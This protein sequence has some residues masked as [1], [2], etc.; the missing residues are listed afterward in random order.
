MGPGSVPLALAAAIGLFTV[1]AVARP[2]R[3]EG[4]SAAFCARRAGRLSYHAK[5]RLPA[6]SFGLPGRRFPMPDVAHARNAKA[7]AVQAFKRGSITGSE[8]RRVNRK[9]D[10]II[11]ACR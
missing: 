9:A 7:R 8:L 4:L 1:A 10:R 3:S 5:K 11:G 2:G 6:S